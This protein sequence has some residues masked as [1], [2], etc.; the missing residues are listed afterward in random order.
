[1]VDALPYMVDYPYGCTEQTLNR[2]L[3]TVIT[4]R[5]LQKMNIDLKEVEKHQTNLN[6]QEI[7]D[8]KERMKQW[9]R[10]PR[11]PV[12]NEGEVKEMVNAGIL[13]L[14]SMQ[15]SD[16]G[17][18]WFS[19]FG[20]R[21]FPHT[22]ATVVHGLQIAQQNDVPIPAA[23]I[24]R[25]LDWLKAYQEDQT[26]RLRNFPTRT[27]P[28]KEHADNMDAMVYM[29]LV[30][31]KIDNQEM[32]GYLYRDRNHLAVYAKAQF[33]LALHKLQDQEKLTMIMKNIEQYS[34]QDA[35]N[36]TAYLRLPPDTPWWY[37]WGSEIESD[38]YYLKLLSL[39]NP[40]DEKAAG[41]VKYLLNNR[42]H[43]T[44]WNSTRD[45]AICI[46]AMADY[47]KASGEDR[48]NMNVEVWLDGKKWKDVHIDQQNL[49]TF[50]N[51]LVLEGDKITA[52]KHTLEIKRRGSGP[53]Y[54]NAYQTNFTLEDFI[55]KA[56]LEVR[57][58]RK[59]YKLDRIDEKIKVSGSK[60]QALDQKV[61]KYKRT[62]LANL[63]TLK[64][65]DLVEVELEIDSKNDY[66]YLIFEDPKAA[67]FEAMAVRSGYTYTGMGAYMEVRDEKIAF[68][69]RVLPRGKHSISYR[70]RAEIPGQ[71]S[72]LPTRA[73]AMY[74]PELKGNSD[75]IKLRIS[76]LRVTD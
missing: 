75:E 72:A 70:M 34:V 5:I 37:W 30:D 38:A 18:G 12:F 2:F 60:G 65:G 61:E 32:R 66:E 20:E 45:T 24:T 69:A 15:L 59:Y 29:V 3:P 23:M 63:A 13:A 62:E 35:E 76:D 22:T 51:K 68:F 33:G 39:T 9:K 43:A 1:M 50:D 67:G 28:W 47:L 7:G 52:G 4:Q 41:L 26:L 58:N 16:G 21:S 74:A 49:F 31:S 73:Y 57:V 71:F 36:Q 44:Y 17:W 55:T 56:G 53:V 10:F 14:G 42:K 46:E 40:R 54:F 64:S 27:F 11:N 25:G 19:G 48:P 8:D 6:A